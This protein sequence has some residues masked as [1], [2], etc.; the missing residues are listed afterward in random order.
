MPRPSR[1]EIWF[2]DFNP[3]RGHEQA[4]LRPALVVSTDQFNQGPADLAVVAP[5]TTRDR[6]VPL[7]VR[8]DPPDGG[9]REASFVMTEA[10]RSVSTDRFDNRKGTVAD[11]TMREVEDRI[12]VLLEL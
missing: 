7:H 8:V 12:R 10:L 6:G 3:I 2:V 5:L 1:G 11:A 4:G 9:I